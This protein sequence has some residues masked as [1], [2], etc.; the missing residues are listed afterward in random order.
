MFLAGE[1]GVSMIGVYLFVIFGNGF[2]YGRNYLFACQLLC[3]VGFIAVLRFAPYWQEHQVA[4]WSLM[5]MVIVLPLYV[6]T[7]LKRI[8][9]VHARARQELDECLAR[10]RGDAAASA[11]MP[12]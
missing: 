5:V 7:L 9:D 11:P 4:D 10:E 1:A 12:R 8:F 2:R 3:I 6:S